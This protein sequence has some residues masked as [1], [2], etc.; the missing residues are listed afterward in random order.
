MTNPPS[1]RGPDSDSVRSAAVS[2]AFCIQPAISAVSSLSTAYVALTGSG[3]TGSEIVDPGNLGKLAGTS[4][5]I[6]PQPVSVWVP[7]AA[8]GG[9]ELA[10]A[11]ADDPGGVSD[12][13]VLAV[14]WSEPQAATTR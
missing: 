5:Q 3:L 8:P 11:E 1:S 14:G 10:S 2:R 4:S 12:R 6:R 13:A 9:M 7:P